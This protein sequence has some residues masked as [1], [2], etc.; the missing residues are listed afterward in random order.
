MY[1]YFHLKF[2]YFRTKIFIR[3]PKTLF[4]I[5]DDF[6]KKKHDIA[7]IIQKVWKGRQQ[8]KRYLEIRQATIVIEKWVRMFLAK[9]R[10]KRRQFAVQTIRNFIE[11]FITRNGPKSDLNQKFIELAKRHYLLW[12]SK[13]LPKKLTENP[14]NSE[15][16]N[17]RCP[18]VCKEVKKTLEIIFI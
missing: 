12:L 11:G 15:V 1:S 18:H 2:N 14:W 17:K 13:N 6:Q 8:R 7:A 10:A 5:E 9:R 4:T 16:F 3:F